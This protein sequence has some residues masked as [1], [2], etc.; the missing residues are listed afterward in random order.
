MDSGSFKESID[1]VDTW[2]L[3]SFEQFHVGTTNSSIL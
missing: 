1:T 3:H 2:Q